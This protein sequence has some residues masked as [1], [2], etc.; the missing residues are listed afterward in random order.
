MNRL[1]ILPYILCALVLAACSGKPKDFMESDKAVVIFPDYAGVTI[2]VNI[3]PLNF[4]VL[5]TCKSVYVEFTGNERSFG[6]LAREKISIPRKKWEKLL[7]E[8]S[9]D[10]IKVTIWTLQGKIWKK[11]RQFGLYVNE[12][13]IDG[14]L[15]YRLIAPGYAG[16]ADMGIYQRN[17]SNFAEKPIVSTKL[18]PNTCMNCH[19]FKQ[20][21]PDHMLFHVRANRGGTF[22]I[23]DE[24]IEKLNTKTDQTISNCVYP[25]W[26]PSGNYVAFSVN[27][28]YQMFHTGKEKRIEVFDAESDLVVYDI[29]NNTLLTDSLISMEASFETF[30]AFSPDG[31]SLIFTSARAKNLP[32]E[33]DEVKYD[34]CKISFDQETGGFGDKVDTLFHASEL[35]LSVSFPR[36]SL[37]GRYLM[38]TVSDYGNFTIWHESADLYLIDLQS[39][40]YKPLAVNSSKTESYHSWSSNSRWFV[41]SS[42]RID[43]LYTRPYIAFIDENGNT[44]KPFLLPQKDPDFYCRFMKSYNIPELVTGPVDFDPYQLEKVYNT[45][46]GTQVGYILNR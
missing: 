31:R 18:L 6:I 44:S 37:D 45:E 27:K 26:H 9:G 42:R 15:V 4:K 35:G 34:L 28:I 19:S 21:D 36:V 43:G 16:Y 7:K 22:L 20:N 41:F 32:D 10:S 46:G 5:D 17:L 23:E 38:F 39:G 30:P 1:Q 3:A 14:Y 11:Y 24:I 2:P 12:V 13:P 25:Y 29:I 40:Q 33:Y 8:N